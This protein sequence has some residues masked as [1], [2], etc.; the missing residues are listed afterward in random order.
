[1]VLQNPIP[2]YK[3]YYI[4][5]ILVII[6][7]YLFSTRLL[8]TVYINYSFFTISLSGSYHWRLREIKKLAQYDQDG[9]KHFECSLSVPNMKKIIPTITE[10]QCSH[11]Y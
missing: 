2:K 9:N 3:I 7:Y 5:Y 11:P 10:T 6:I 4:I 1:M 8:G